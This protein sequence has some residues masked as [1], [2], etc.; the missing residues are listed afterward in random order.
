VGVQEEGGVD[1][2]VEWSD[3]CCAGKGGALWCIVDD[4]MGVVGLQQIWY[5]KLIKS[6]FQSEEASFGFEVWGVN[7]AITIAV[8]AAVIRW[9]PRLCLAACA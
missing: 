3:L 7:P 9:S 5:I 6:V 2:G 4:P 8:S 1:T